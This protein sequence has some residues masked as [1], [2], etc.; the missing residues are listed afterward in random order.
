ML[1][2]LQKVDQSSVHGSMT[3]LSNS[4]QKVSSEMPEA[5]NSDGSVGH[6][7][8]S[9]SS[10][11][12]GFGLQLGPPS[13]RISI[14]NHSLSS[15]STH[16]VRSSH[17]HATEETGEKSRGQMCPPHQGQS[18]PPAEH[19]MEELKNNRSGVPGSTYNEASLYTIP[20]KFSSAFDSGF[21][22]LGSPLQNPPVVRATGQLSTNHS[23]NVSFDR[24][25]PSS[26]EKGDSH[27]GPGSG[28]PVQ[29]SIPKGTGDDK[30]D[31][32]SISAGKSHLSNVNGPHQR[33]SANQVSSKEPR[34]VSQP[35]STSGTTQQGAYS[36]MFSNMW[37]NFPPRQPPFVA[38]STKEPSHIHQS[39]Q[40]NNMESSLSAAERQGDVDAN[41]G[42]KFT[43]EVGTSTVNILGSVEGE[44]E[45]VIESASRQVELVQMNDTQDK[46]PVTNL[47][48][49]S[50]ANST[51]MQRDIEAFGRTLKP[52]S[53]PQPSYSLLNQMQVMKDVETD[54]SERSLKRMRVSDSHT[55]VQQI[56]STDSRILSF[57]GRENLQGSVSLQLGGN[58]TPQD[59][60]ASHHD[61][62]QSSFQNNS[63]NS[64]K[65][66]HTQIS[67][68]MAPSWF[69]QYG[70]FKNAQMLQMYE[71]NRAASKKTTDQPFTP[72][73]SFNVLQTFDSIQRVIPTNAD[74]SN[75]GQSS[76]AGSA[77]IED[78]S[79]PQ[80]LPL[81]VGQHHQLLKPMKRKRLT[82]EL[83][84]WCKEVSLDSRGKQTIRFIFCSTFSKL[85]CFHAFLLLSF[86][87][88]C[89]H[90]DCL[91]SSSGLMIFVNLSICSLAETEWA[92]ST[93][94][95]VEKV[96]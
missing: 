29:S 92:K 88:I 45:R 58:V 28:Q 3:Q 34:S 31:N 25:G 42:W 5:E 72:G 26:A 89:F 15:L 84:P 38:Q 62:A 17:S 78:F 4:E 53:F 23:I 6:L 43:S 16:T 19:S 30:Q 82:S 11:S 68:Q 51:S 85:L 87:P 41:K 44:E 80:T 1:Q 21:P 74:R 52:N 95:L 60:L 24:H 65:P 22:Y 71:A 14:P 40:L 69:N 54:P 10:A 18:L 55:G 90:L 9:Q 61:D 13:Q 20:G 76:S 39:H 12:Q 73:K 49:G 48:E 59:V 79:S 36:K 46:E 35:I 66:E 47:S 83:T 77:A 8:Q 37:T 2:L 86:I 96:S 93:N 81:N 70:T 94:R 50:P 63:T 67:P 33:I 75:L 91:S 56:L 64:F 7:Q 57:S 27:R 32:P